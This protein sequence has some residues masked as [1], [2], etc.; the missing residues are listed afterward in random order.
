MSEE[1]CAKM[2]DVANN[3]ELEN[4]MRK[5]KC[6]KDRFYWVGR[7]KGNTVFWLAVSIP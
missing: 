2:M 7:E 1:T 6:L 5:L 3:L 4:S